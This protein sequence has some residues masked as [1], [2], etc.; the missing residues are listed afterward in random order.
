MFDRG[1]GAGTVGP[2]TQWVADH[3]GLL[4][5]FLLAVLGLLLIAWENPTGKVV[6]M[7]IVIGLVGLLVIQLLAAGAKRTDEPVA[8]D[9]ADAPDV[10]ATT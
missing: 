7:L 10:P 8:V 9:E 3:V 6:L 1:D 5:G 4:R 2:I